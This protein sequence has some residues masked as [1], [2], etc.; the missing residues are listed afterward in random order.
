M[1][2]SV[3]S[4]QILRV[5]R[6]NAYVLNALSA[7]M[8]LARCALGSAKT[9]KNS[10][11]LKLMKRQR[12]AKISAALIVYSYALTAKTTSAI[13]AFLRLLNA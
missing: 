8:F 6:I 9:L 7:I 4:A 11:H 2:L 10:N 5:I 1:P 3:W 12:D 13:N